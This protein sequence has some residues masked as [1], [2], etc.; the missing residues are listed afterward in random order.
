MQEEEEFY[1]L[2]NFPGVGV[3]GAI[4]THV[5]LDCAPLGENKFTYVNRKGIHSLNI[6]LVCEAKYS[7]TN[8]VAKR[9]GLCM[10]INA[11]HADINL[12]VFF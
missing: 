9:P 4:C 1:L 7:I 2:S 12:G 5:P 6:Q 3:V 10:D 8:V 11:T